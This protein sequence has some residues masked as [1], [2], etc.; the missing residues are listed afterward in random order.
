MNLAT[1]ISTAPPPPATHQLDRTAGIP[2]WSDR[3]QRLPTSSSTAPVAARSNGAQLA[4]LGRPLVAGT[5]RVAIDSTF[6]LADARA[7]HERAGQAGA[8][9]ELALPIGR[10][11]QSRKPKLSPSQHHRHIPVYSPPRRSTLS[12]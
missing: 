8:R 1:P 2:R 4:E 11:F 6:A 5:V 7:A 9:H 12:S 10:V 3:D